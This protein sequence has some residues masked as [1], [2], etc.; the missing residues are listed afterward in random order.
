MIS[1]DRG[2]GYMMVYNPDNPDSY[3]DTGYKGW[4]MEHRYIAEQYILNRPIRKTDCV[5]HIDLNRS[6]NDP[7]N[8]IVFASNADHSRFHGNGLR[9][10]LLIRHEDG[11]CSCKETIFCIDCGA[12]VWKRGDR[13]KKCAQL[14][15][16]KVERPNKEQLI[17]DVYSMSMVQIG[18]K[19]GVSD[20]A[21][22]KWL[23]QYGYTA[24]KIKEMIRESRI[25]RR[26]K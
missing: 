6:N 15:S 12:K 5:H 26:K 24:D 11:S 22:R 10:E 18:K 16:R 7:A 14:H 2:D 1:K 17:E 13:C 25:K 4:M 21:V 8:L 9:E 20:N 3:K 23:K 19:Y